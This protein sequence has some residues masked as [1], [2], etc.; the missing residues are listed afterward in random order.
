MSGDFILKN[1]ADI[2]RKNITSD[3]FVCRYAGDEFAILTLYNYK[4][5]RE[6]LVS[7]IE[8]YEF[9]QNV[10]TSISIGIADYDSESTL[11]ESMMD[12]A[13][14]INKYRKHSIDKSKRS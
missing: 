9:H 8:E 2:L 10:P 1:I 3:M 14:K 5:F 11:N 4:L 13:K 6:K 12:I 7:D